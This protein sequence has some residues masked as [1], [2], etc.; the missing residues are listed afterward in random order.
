[1][2]YLAGVALSRLGIVPE[3]FLQ[4]TPLELDHA[5]LDFDERE[6]NKLEAVLIN[7]S[8]MMRWQTMKLMNIQGRI[9]KN[10]IRKPQQLGKFSWKLEREEKERPKTPEE[11]KEIC[12]RAF[13]FK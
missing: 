12:L 3:E 2:D 9:M 10:P 13:G 1:M 11:M 5:L 4:I 8:E 7:N 6:K